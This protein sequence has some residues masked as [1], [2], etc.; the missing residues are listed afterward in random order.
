MNFQNF[1]HAK[2][3]FT[4]HFPFFYFSHRKLLVS[5]R[6]YIYRISV[7]KWE[8]DFLSCKIHC[9]LRKVCKIRLEMKF[10]KPHT[11]TL[12]SLI[13]KPCLMFS[14]WFLQFQAWFLFLPHFSF[15]SFLSTGYRISCG[16]GENCSFVSIIFQEVGIEG[17][18]IESVGKGEG[19]CWGRFEP[20]EKIKTS[21][22]VAN[23]KRALRAY[24]DIL[25]DKKGR[26]ESVFRWDSVTR[27][28]TS[29][30]FS[31]GTSISRDTLLHP[32]KRNPSNSM[33]CIITVNV[34]LQSYAL[35]DLSLK[36]C[37]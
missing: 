1:F 19:E 4:T 11:H 8:R 10:Q 35:T 17:G 28:E 16:I 12:G 25:F 20:Q 7:G 22:H 26:V 6:V 9:P 31:I 5:C 14:T 15:P 24:D 3:F 34:F 33:T 37:S 2:W 18:R 23:V 27:V 21:G 13:R 30:S 29:I 36:V 32:T